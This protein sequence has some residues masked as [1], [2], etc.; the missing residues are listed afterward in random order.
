MEEDK[1]GATCS[2]HIQ[3]FGWKPEG[4]KQLKSSRVGWVHDIKMILKELRVT[5]WFGFLR[6]R[7]G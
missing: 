5:V 3:T 1:T 2:T 4:K 7:T 6:L